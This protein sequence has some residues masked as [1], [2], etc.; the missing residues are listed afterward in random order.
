VGAGSANGRILPELKLGAGFADS[1]L[2][3]DLRGSAANQCRPRD[4]IPRGRHWAFQWP[5]LKWRVIFRPARRLAIETQAEGHQAL[6]RLAAP[7]NS[8]RSHFPQLNPKSGQLEARWNVSSGP[9]G[10]PLPS[11]N[12]FHIT[13]LT[14]VDTLTSR[15]Y[16]LRATALMAEKRDFAV[17]E[18]DVIVA[19]AGDALRYD[20]CA[21]KRIARC[22]MSGLVFDKLAVSFR[23]LSS[24]AY[25]Q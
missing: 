18:Y 17:G 2:P 11:V 6:V 15:Q 13:K 8:I 3:G 7:Q 16:E 25:Q 14:T 20:F 22:L 21:R 10:P 4:D 23:R 12:S 5:V 1:S 24:R 9:F 19:G